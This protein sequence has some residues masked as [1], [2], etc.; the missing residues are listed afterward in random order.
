[1]DEQKCI[2][3]RGKALGGDTV[4]NDMLYTRG[5]PRDYDTWSDNGVKGWCWES[6]EPY[7]KQIENACIK[8]MDKKSRHYGKGLIFR[9]FLL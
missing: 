7:F 9:Y 5:H 6:L 1:M 4:V 8:Y 2:L 3:R